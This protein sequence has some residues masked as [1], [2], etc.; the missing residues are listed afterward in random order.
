MSAPSFFESTYHPDWNGSPYPSTRFR[1]CP[2]ACLSHH[3]SRKGHS[4]RSGTPGAS[5]GILAK[6]EGR[7]QREGSLVAAVRAPLTPGPLTKSGCLGRS[8]GILP[9]LIIV[10]LLY[11]SLLA[12]GFEV[13]LRWPEGGLRVA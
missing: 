9:A 3:S 6:L 8:D 10:S 1:E 11:G 4:C 12:L 5:W 7:D 13:A 2:L